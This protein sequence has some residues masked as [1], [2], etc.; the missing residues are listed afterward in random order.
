MKK[1]AIEMKD[2]RKT[3]GKDVVAINDLSLTIEEGTIY[4]L[5][6]PN[7]SGKTTTIRILTSLAAADAGDIFLFDKKLNTHN[8]KKW[9]GCVAQQSGV[10]PMGT[11]RE[12]LM[13]QGRI[14][15]L[16]GKE[17]KK[18]VE[19]LLERFHLQKDANRLSMKYSGGMKRKLD[20]AMG[21][22]H[23]PKLLFLDEPTTGLDPE[24][25]ED[26]WKTI[27]QL[28]SEEGLTVVLTTH[29]MEEA[30]E[31][32]DRVAFMNEG[33]IVVEGTA[34]ELKNKLGGDTLTIQCTDN[35]QAERAKEIL[36]ALYHVTSDERTLY[37]H[38]EQGAEEL[39][40]IF[41]VL[42]S[43]QTEVRSAAVSRPALGDVYLIYTGKALS[44]ETK[45]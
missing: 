33:K 16:K 13:L 17:L 15:G 30:D 2:V 32:S 28:Q 18:R 24:A 45:Q 38:S 19:E 29:Y 21:L 3:Y 40:K 43:E 42:E 12:N 36:R 5:L 20:L 31:L 37:V 22:I 27:R 41:K 1:T 6:G 26:L 7:G 23:H 25:R 9:I 34:E 10:D 14:H 44:E 35:A 39:P 4:A 11:G 8:M